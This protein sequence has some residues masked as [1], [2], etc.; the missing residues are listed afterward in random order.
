LAKGYVF[1]KFDTTEGLG[2]MATAKRN[3]VR[4]LLTRGYAESEIAKIL[5]GNLLRVYRQV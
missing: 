5:G 4:E 3:L 1:G 2:D